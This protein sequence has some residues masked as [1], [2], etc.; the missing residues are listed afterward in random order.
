[1]LPMTHI[2]QVFIIVATILF[3]CA[4]IGVPWGNLVAAGLFF[5]TLGLLLGGYVGK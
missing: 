4:T 3:G 2:G 5:L 1:M